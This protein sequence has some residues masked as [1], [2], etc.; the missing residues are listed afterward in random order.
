MSTPFEAPTILLLVTDRIVD[1]EE[2][3]DEMTEPGTSPHD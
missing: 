2:P 1:A 3:V